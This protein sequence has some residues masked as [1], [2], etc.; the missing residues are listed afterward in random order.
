MTTVFICITTCL[1]ATWFIDFADVRAKN[2]YNI[3]TEIIEIRPSVKHVMTRIK[4]SS[5]STN[6]EPLEIFFKDKED[7]AK[8][9]KIFSKQNKEENFLELYKKHAIYDKRRKKYKL[10]LEEAMF[11]TLNLVKV[12]SYFRE[13]HIK[14][15]LNFSTNRAEKKKFFQEIKPFLSKKKRIA[16]L[17]KLKSV[18]SF[19]VEDELF[20]Y[21]SKKSVQR[22]TIYRGPNCFHSS[23]AFQGMNYSNSIKFNSKLEKEHH[24]IMINNDELYRALTTQ[25]YELDIANTPL[26]YGDLI[27]FLDVPFKTKD[28]DSHY[29]YSWIKHATVF[30]LNK[31]TFSKGSKSASSAYTIKTL[32][33]ELK[34]WKKHLKNLKIKVYRKAQKNLNKNF[35]RPRADWVY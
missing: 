2:Y 8:K 19:F 24:R 18:N 35:I 11:K 32:N 25:F 29:H 33:R 13:K 1:N 3:D 26:V 17:N 27:I 16:V 10:A 15:Y 23:L 14:L 6:I 5:K 30:L 28:L 20:P 4:Q 31:Y 9:A 21:F 7:A 22:Y 34:T 12:I